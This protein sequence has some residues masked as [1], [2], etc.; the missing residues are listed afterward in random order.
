MLRAGPKQMELGPD[1]GALSDGFHANEG[2]HRWTDGHARLIPEVLAGFPGDVSLVLHLSE[3]ELHYP[4]DA[5]AGIGIVAP[6]RQVA[7]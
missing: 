7:S 1:H 4:A 2:S 6:A 3:T 5:V